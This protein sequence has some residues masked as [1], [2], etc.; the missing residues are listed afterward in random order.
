MRIL[1]KRTLREFWEQ[2]LYSYSKGQLEAWHEEVGKADWS[3]PQ[4]LKEQ[5]RS[6]S[7]IKIAG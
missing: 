1:S 2:P 3:T 6:A 4:E 7:I 5:F